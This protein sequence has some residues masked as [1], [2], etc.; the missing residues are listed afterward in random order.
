MNRFD[1]RAS[2]PPLDRRVGVRLDFAG[3]A[4][5]RVV[6]HAGLVI[7]HVQTLVG[8]AGVRYRAKRFHARSRAFR[9]LG[10]FWSPDDAI[11]CLRYAR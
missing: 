2:F 3:P 11:D 9:A 8:D 4:L 10:D 6:D 5:W 7:G 1:D